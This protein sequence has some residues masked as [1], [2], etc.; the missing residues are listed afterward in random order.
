MAEFDPKKRRPITINIR[1]V[2]GQ[3]IDG[4]KGKERRVSHWVQKDGGQYCW[5]AFS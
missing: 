1:A 5:N 3:I 2:V 4:Y